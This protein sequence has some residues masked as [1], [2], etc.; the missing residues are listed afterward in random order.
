MKAKAQV[1]ALVDTVV[2]NQIETLIDK[3]AEMKV[4][5]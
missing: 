2:V 1:E 3:V 5:P 4:E